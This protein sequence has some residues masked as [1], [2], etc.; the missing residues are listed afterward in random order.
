MLKH[1][2][3]TALLTSTLVCSGEASFA[4]EF[5]TLEEAKAMLA[6]AVAAVKSDNTAAIAK[7]NHNDSAFRDR[8]LFV[9]CFNGRD[10]K[11]TAHEAFVGH[12]VRALVDPAGKHF[13]AEM[14]A[15]PQEGG[16]TEVAFLS[17]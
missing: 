9:F 5:G 6:R 8:D 14:F 17:P 7:F 15:A 12:D 3:C 13:G 1:L 2:L 4:N 11:F 10:G 16:T